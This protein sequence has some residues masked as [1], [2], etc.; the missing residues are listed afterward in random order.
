MTIADMPFATALRV[1]GMIAYGCV[2]YANGYNPKAHE[3]L[4]IRTKGLLPDGETL[5]EFTI[6]PEY[7][8]WCGDDVDAAAWAACVRLTRTAQAEALAAAFP[9]VDFGWHKQTD[10]ELAA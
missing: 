1:L 5:P 9:G 7:P 10:A 2:D 3:M 4:L 6:T 8:L